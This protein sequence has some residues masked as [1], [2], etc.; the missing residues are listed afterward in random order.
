MLVKY[1][2]AWLSLIRE[3]EVI[4]H[5]LIKHPFIKQPSSEDKNVNTLSKLSLVRDVK[6][7]SKEPLFEID[8]RTGG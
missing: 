7:G 3:E 1:A 5:L 6:Y 2:T 8:K 4:H